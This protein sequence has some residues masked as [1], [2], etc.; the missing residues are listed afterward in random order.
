MRIGG[1]AASKFD[2]YIQDVHK[3]LCFFKGSNLYSGLW[4]LSVSARCECV[5]TIAGQTQAL[6]QSS[7]KSQHFKEKKIFKEHPVQKCKRCFPLMNSTKERE[8]F[9]EHIITYASVHMYTFIEYII[10]ILS[11]PQKVSKWLSL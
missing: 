6:P 4:S 5:C 8:K 9:L 7:E 10:Y 11:Y 2:L 3:K 1:W